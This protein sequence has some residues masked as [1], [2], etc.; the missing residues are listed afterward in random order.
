MNRKFVCLLTDNV[1]SLRL[2]KLASRWGLDTSTKYDGSISDEPFEFHMTLL[3]SIGESS[4]PNFETANIQPITVNGACLM[5]LGDKAT[6]IKT[7][8]PS[9]LT[10]L[11]DHIIRDMRLTHNFEDFLPH[12]SISYNPNHDL[13]LPKPLWYFPIRFNRVAIRNV[14]D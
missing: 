5:K 3:Y 7:T 14:D 1:T 11:R 2:E 13:N 9:D 8:C 10:R 6:A 12:V 4:Y